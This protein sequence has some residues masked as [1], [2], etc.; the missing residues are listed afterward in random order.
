[1]IRILASKDA[2]R[3]L[4]RKAA[5]M[6]EAEAAV[7]PILADVRK[8]GDAALMEY[9]RKFDGLARRSVHV[10]EKELL[11][12]RAGLAPDFARA[13]ETA[14]QNVRAFA[15]KQMPA[16]WMRRFQPGLRLGQ[17]VRPLESVAAYIPSGRY[18]LPSTIVMT[19]VPAQV[20]GVPRISIASPRPVAEVFGTAALLG[21]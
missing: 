10:P 9:A 11:A 5:R 18:P 4:T 19:V 1:V 15:Q 2:G 3:L 21:A 16:E 6:A 14:A 20:A 7:A 17:I 8:R 13:V 12:A